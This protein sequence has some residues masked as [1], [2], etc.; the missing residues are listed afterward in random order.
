MPFCRQPKA[1]N[2]KQATQSRQP[3]AR[4]EGAAKGIQPKSTA[5]LS[6][7]ECSNVFEIR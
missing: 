5:N 6:A 7:F 2:P 3:K 1:G 4:A